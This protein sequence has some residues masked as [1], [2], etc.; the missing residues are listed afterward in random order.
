MW[1]CLWEETKVLGTG[2]WEGS[3]ISNSIE[4]ISQYFART[5]WYITSKLSSNE[6]IKKKR[7]NKIFVENSRRGNKIWNKI[8][9]FRRVAL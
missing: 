9:K 7:R 8:E 1:S 3:L 4:K 5:D 6:N 2:V